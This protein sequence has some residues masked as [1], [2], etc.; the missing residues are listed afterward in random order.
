MSAGASARARDAR[1]AGESA[2]DRSTQVAV[3]IVT[4]NTR[5]AVLDCLATIAAAVGQTVT[6]RHSHHGTAPEQPADEG[7]ERHEIVVVDNGSTDGTA[8]A[9]RAAFPHVSVLEL[10]NAGFGRGANAGVAATRAETV[11]VANADVRF[12]PGAIAALA[13]TLAAAPAVGAVG[14]AVR[15]ADGV[16]QASARSVPSAAVAAGHAVLGRV[17]PANPA[18]RRYFALDQQ[19]A[20][21]PPSVAPDAERAR[22]AEWLSGCAIAFRR[23]AYDHVG[24]FDPGFFLFMEDVDVA[25]RLR[26]AGWRLRYD[27]AAEIVHVGGASTSRHPYRRAIW[28]ARSLDRFHRK[29]RQGLVGVL[30]R[31]FV[32]VGLAGWIALAVVETLVTRLRQRRDRD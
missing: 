5:D 2:G 17:W 9:V 12:R 23:A 1:V 19:H 27:P 14:P 7:Y 3:V 30:A 16:L 32:R 11:V 22:D 29:H 18:T 28:H 31:P 26:A 8:D 15:D 20:T 25:L 6:E 24:G 4:H 21:S 10:A 13:A